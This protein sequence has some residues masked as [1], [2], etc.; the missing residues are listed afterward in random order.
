[1]QKLNNHKSYDK[2]KISGLYSKI[3]TQRNSS[4]RYFNSKSHQIF[5]NKMILILYKIRKIGKLIQKTSKLLISKL[6]KNAMLQE[7]KSSDH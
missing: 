6:D 2:E 1:M 5:R 7:N 4:P 3:F